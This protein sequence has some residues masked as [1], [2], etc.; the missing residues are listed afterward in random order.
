MWIKGIQHYEAKIHAIR[1]SNV[2]NHELIFGYVEL[3]HHHNWLDFEISFIVLP[4]NIIYTY[5]VNNFVLHI[6]GCSFKPKFDNYLAL[7]D[8]S[9]SLNFFF[10][11]VLVISN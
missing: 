9:N 4:N 11:G 8:F 3:L 10:F 7:M 1:S 6:Q 2:G 5:F